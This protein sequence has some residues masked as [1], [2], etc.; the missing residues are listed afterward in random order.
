MRSAG[1][2]FEFKTTAE[3]HLYISKDDGL[4]RYKVQTREGEISQQFF[5][6]IDYVVDRY[7]RSN[8]FI[9]DFKKLQDISDVYSRQTI[10]CK[11]QDNAIHLINYTTNELGK[12]LIAPLM[13]GLLYD[14]RR[15]YIVDI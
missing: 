10:R 8:G 5:V 15:F 12:D 6:P 2:E 7:N 4:G 9:V 14:R 13:I 3:H 11:L 1:R